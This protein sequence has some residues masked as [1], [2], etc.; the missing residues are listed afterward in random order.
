ML[1]SVCTIIT[2]ADHTEPHPQLGY[3]GNISVVLIPDC[4]SGG[5]KSILK[6]TK[7]WLQVPSPLFRTTLN[8]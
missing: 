8:R 6:Q 5:A 4:L 1:D 2:G 7:I 3:S